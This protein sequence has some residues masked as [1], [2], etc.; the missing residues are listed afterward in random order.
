[1]LPFCT[2]APLMMLVV[3]R[4]SYY[5]CGQELDPE[6]FLQTHF[7]LLFSGLCLQKGDN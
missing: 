6:R 5:S 4:Y 2:V 1:M 7:D 3:W